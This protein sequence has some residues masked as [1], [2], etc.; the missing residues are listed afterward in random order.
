MPFQLAK[1]VFQLFQLLGP[2]G[3]FVT[4]LFVMLPYKLWI[5]FV[6]FIKNAIIS[7]LNFVVRFVDLFLALARTI[8]DYF[9][10]W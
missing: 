3:L 9:V 7:L 1:V 4:W 10:P 5:K 6:L 2:L 8:A